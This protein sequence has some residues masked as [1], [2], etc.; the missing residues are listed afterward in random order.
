MSRRLVID[1]H[2]PPESNVAFDL[3]GSR[4]GISVRPGGIRIALTTHD[5]IVVVCRPLPA[6]YARRIRRRHE[7]PAHT[8]SRKVRVPVNADGGRGLGNDLP[9]PRGPGHARGRR[10]GR[11]R[12]PFALGKTIK[13]VHQ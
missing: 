4:P 2:T 5:D 6:T 12:I 3:I 13:D 9:I 8:L 1:L 7:F 10:F 11:G